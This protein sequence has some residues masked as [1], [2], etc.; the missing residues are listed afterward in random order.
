M[1][2]APINDISM[3]YEDH[4]AGDA[5]ILIA[6]FSAD[7]TVWEPIIDDL[8]A[9]YRV[10]T[11]DN[12]GAGQTTVPETDYTIDQMAAD[13]I[14]LC[15]YLSITSTHVLGNSMGGCITQTLAHQ[16][17]D[18]VRKAI[19][20]NSAMIT[21]CTFRYYLDAHYELM[22]A[23]APQEAIF[24]ASRSWVFSYAYLSQPGML[25]E[26]IH[27]A[28]HSPHPFTPV[29]FKGQNAALTQFDSRP[30]TKDITVPTLV[31]TGSED[32]IFN[33]TLSKQMAASIPQAQY[34]CFE[35]VGHLP[36][37]ENPQEFMTVLTAFLSQ[38]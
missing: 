2:L 34:H 35:S 27:T 17:P 18:Y 14:A 7:H 13:V 33:S 32:I 1:P 23:N 4:G 38:P 26:I 6:G 19:I 24:K 11:L 16:Y 25:D 28:T 30:W 5:I 12:R 31:I 3:Y 8:S 15:D 21:E 20:S 9:H 36:F 22:C 10:I 37:V 29:G